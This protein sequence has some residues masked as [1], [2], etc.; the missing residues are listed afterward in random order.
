[1]TSRRTRKRVF[2]TTTERRSS[3]RSRRFLGVIAAAV[4]VALFAAG[5]AGAQPEESAEDPDLEARRKALDA[6]AHEP[7]HL[8]GPS[9]SMLFDRADSSFYF[10]DPRTQTR[11]Y[12]SWK[13]R[14]FAALHLTDGTTLPIDRVEHLRASGERIRFRGASTAGDAPPVE[15]EFHSNGPP[16]ALSLSFTVSEDAR[17]AIESVTLLDGALWT[18]DADD[19]S[20]RLP[21]GPG[22]RFRAAGEPQTLRLRGDEHVPLGDGTKRA[23]VSPLMGVERSGQTLLVF[24]T[25]RRAELSIERRSLEDDDAFPGATGAFPSIRIPGP[26]GDVHFVGGLLEEIGPLDITRAYR[27]AFDA[28]YQRA[29]LRYKTGQRPE[30]EPFLGG[31]FFP[32]AIHDA[33]HLPYLHGTKRF[34]FDDVARLSQHFAETLGVRDAT[35]VLDRWQGVARRDTSP[36]A[37][38]EPAGGSAGLAACASALRARKHLLGLV[39]HRDQLV[40]RYTSE[41]VTGADAWRKALD[42][43]VSSQGF[44]ALRKVCEPELLVV[45]EPAGEGL[46]PSILSARSAF[47]EEAR[48]SIRLVGTN[49]WSDDAI[50]Q[51]AYVE[52]AF[53]PKLQLPASEF[54]PLSV[55]LLGQYQRLAPKPGEAIRPDQADRLLASILLGQAPALE[56]PDAKYAD[57]RESFDGPGALFCREGGWS[58]G[59]DLSPR[60][61][62]IKNAYELAGRLSSFQSRYPLVKFR[63]LTSDGLVVES[64]FGYDMRIVVNFGS[65]DY[66]NDDG[67]LILPPLGFVVRYP[68]FLAF[69]ARRIDGKHY[70][71]P[72]FFTLESLEGKMFL[73][74]ES[75]RIYHGFGPSTIRVG[76]RDFVVER[77]S[78]QRVW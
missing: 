53:P 10:L 65:K 34:D 76:A 50:Q 31:L 5:F 52:G 61:R 6:W 1:M 57:R 13:R 63:A 68:F 71:E 56:L 22:R 16:G 25:D 3:R 37:A 55:S 4:S 70:D 21:L 12:S 78:V 72:A 38:S 73:R 49:L 66:E 35:F 27:A 26:G 20:V 9:L 77:E 45:R 59:L 14:G 33:T 7:V 75:S 46:D 2:G 23:Y 41:P 40:R 42:T 39:V 69:H 58:E 67:S 43:V 28:T 19:G 30:L 48:Q 62:F 60:D 32:V 36:F 18:A 11:W 54:Y 29:T 74:A 17:S 44:P 47:F 24:W 51:I 15:F 64:R 8:R